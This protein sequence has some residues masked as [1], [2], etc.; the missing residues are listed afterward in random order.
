MNQQKIKLNAWADRPTLP[1]ISLNFLVTGYIFCALNLG[2]WPRAVEALSG[3]AFR[4]T[5]F[6]LA[7]FSLTM[8]L[9]ELL[10]PG[11]LQKPVAAALILIAA[12]ASYFERS[13][14]ILI[15]REMMRNIF[16]TT[17]TEAQHLITPDAVFQIVLLGVLPAILVFWPKV[18][19]VGPWNQFWRWPLGVGLS[20]AIV[21]GGIYPDYRAYSAAFRER[22]DVMASLQPVASIRA[23][24]DYTE[25]Q[26]QSVAAEVQ[27]KGADAK[28][29]PRLEAADRPILLVVFVGETLRAQNFSLNG[30]VRDTTPGLATRDV[31]NFSD[32]TACGTSTSVSLPCMF[33]QLPVAEFA[34]EK[35]MSQENLL[36]VLSRADFQLEW[37]ENNTGDMGVAKRLGWTHVDQTLDPQSCEGECTDEIL[38][39]VITKT[40]SGIT[41]NTVLFLHMNGNHGPAYFMRYPSE[42]ATFQ[43]DCRTA[44]FSDCT[45]EAIVNAYDNAVLETDYVL[46]RAIDMLAASDKVLPAMIFLSDHGESLGENGLYLHAAPRFMAPEEQIK[47]PMVIWL[48]DAFRTTMAIDEVCLQNVAQQPVSHDNL[49]HTVLGLLDVTTVARDQT[50]DLVSNCRAVGSAS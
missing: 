25:Q 11:R 36:D 21:I 43:P 12:S 34:R 27:V 4:I 33:S 30:Y 40:L 49:F 28:P 32:V 45:D 14:G 18:L 35:A 37:V 5:V 22:G 20:A 41:H 2:F 6:G 46:S 48:G 8:M 42:R 19:R 38:L 9:L 10:G 24:I 44:Q 7:V 29:G 39:P 31:I 17:P 13:F 16:E 47:V 26:L 23:L 15:D 1:H 3:N 50:L